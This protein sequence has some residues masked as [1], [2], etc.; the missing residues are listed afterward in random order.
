M[1]VSHERGKG[2]REFRLREAALNSQKSQ[3]ADSF[4]LSDANS[5][6]QIIAAQVVCDLKQ[7]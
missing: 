5:L 6:L 4:P 1:K 2:L 7:K 3:A